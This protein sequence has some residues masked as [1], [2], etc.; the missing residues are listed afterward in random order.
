[1]IDMV[2]TCL[3]ASVNIHTLH[4]L[5]GRRF[6]RER[7]WQFRNRFRLGAGTKI[8][9]VGGVPDTWESVSE[10]VDVTILNLFAI[11]WQNRRGYPAITTV[12][13]DGCA[14]PYSDGVFDIVFSNSVIEHLGTAERQQMFATEVRRVGRSLWVQTPSKSFPI[15]SHLLTP[16]I[17]YLPV[18]VRV[19]LL[20][21]FT[22]WGLLTRP[23]P[24][25]VQAFLAEVRLLSAGEMQAL[26][27]D[28]TIV[29]ERVIGLSKSY[30]AVRD[31]Q[32]TPSA[33]VVAS[34]DLRD[35][36]PTFPAT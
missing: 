16:F 36:S 1:M 25:Q 15:E 14:L 13:G 30:I 9:D 21:R 18:A 6:R 5:A 17:H 11:P 3:T 10:D 33:M 31:A 23:S 27:P 35:S 24:Q 28:C 12:V 7:M 29:R 32:N 20:R 4:Y 19:K 2:K 26:F 8:L 34:V 22:T